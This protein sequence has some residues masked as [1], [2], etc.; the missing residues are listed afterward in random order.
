MVHPTASG[1]TIQTIRTRFIEL[2]EEAMGQ[3]EDQTTAKPR[4]EPEE[5]GQV[6][7]DAIQVKVK[8]FF[9]DWQ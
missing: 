3:P 5:P 7:E 8:R 1:Y 6:D 4:H 2:L 9:S